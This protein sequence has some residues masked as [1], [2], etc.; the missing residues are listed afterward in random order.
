MS[1][2][3]RLLPAV[4]GALCLLAPRLPDARAHGE[5]TRSLA[6]ISARIEAE[7]AGPVDPHRRAKLF[8]ERGELFRVHRDFRRAARDYDAAERYQPRLAAIAIARTHMLHESGHPRQAGRVLQAFLATAPGH[9][10]ALQL[11]AR[12]LT[13]LGSRLG[14][15][16]AL[17]RAIARL[18]QPQPDHYLL[19]ADLLA[20]LGRRHLP[21]AVQGLDEGIR[22]LGP[23]V[24]LDSRA[25]ELELTLGR[26]EQALTRIDRQA[27]ATVRK[28]RW[29][30]RRAD[31]L[32]RAGRAQ[33]ARVARQEALR[34]LQA[35]PPSLQTRPGTRQLQQELLVAVQAQ[36][37]AE[38]A[39]DPG[40]EKKGAP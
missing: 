2:V 36:A 35:L 14:A 24:S 29:L 8:L 1:S 7:V 33:E 9:A 16:Q 23:L 40:R 22:R 32:D 21:R 5:H 28:D 30:A 26:H 20:G 31:V 18:A 6:A 12:L 27:A 15:V 17:D 4:C 39:R 37:A 10:E 3:P 38:P 19:R 11:Q 34:A 13:A 25:I